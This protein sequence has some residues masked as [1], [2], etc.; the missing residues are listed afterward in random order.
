MVPWRFQTRSF[1]SQLLWRPYVT[2]K[3]D[4]TLSKDMGFAAPFNTPLICARSLRTELSVRIFS[5]DEIDPQCERRPQDPHDVATPAKKITEDWTRS[6]VLRHHPNHA[7]PEDLQYV[8]QHRLN[9]LMWWFHSYEVGPDDRWTWTRFLILD[10]T[11]AT[12]LS[13]LSDESPRHVLVVCNS[14]RISS[15]SCGNVRN[16]RE[17]DSVLMSLIFPFLINFVTTSTQLRSLNL[18][19]VS[20]FWTASSWACKSA[21][22]V[23]CEVVMCWLMVDL[24]SFAKNVRVRP[25]CGDF[26]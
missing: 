16:S 10:I 6:Q 15:S 21:C 3:R 1:L 11:W 18:Y 26:F 12:C 4:A 9:M 23:C 13:L 8:W 19:F 5:E 14:S 22:N 2:H 7:V 17:F 25:L 20:I 24:Y